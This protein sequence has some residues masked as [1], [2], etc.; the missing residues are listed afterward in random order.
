MKNRM[1][2]LLALAFLSALNVGDLAFAQVVNDG[3]TNTLNNVTS[4]LTRCP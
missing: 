1:F 3:T 4:N 2:A